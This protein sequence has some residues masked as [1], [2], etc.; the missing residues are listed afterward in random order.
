MEMEEEGLV[1]ENKTQETAGTKATFLQK[2]N[3]R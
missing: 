1:C 2:F 3:V